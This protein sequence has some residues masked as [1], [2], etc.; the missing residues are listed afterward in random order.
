MMRLSASSPPLLISCSPRICDFGLARTVSHQDSRITETQNVMSVFWTAPEILRNE[1]HTQKA[2]V[3]SFG[4]VRVSCFV[5]TL[6]EIRE[7]KWLKVY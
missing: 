4:V 6:D 5:F 1:D 2:D 7:I 3:Y